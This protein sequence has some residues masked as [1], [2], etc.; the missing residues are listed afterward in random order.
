MRYCGEGRWAASILLL[1]LFVVVSAC[2][3]AA[4]PPAAQQPAAA[5]PPETKAAA[6]AKGKID[7]ITISAFN[8]IA[9][10]LPAFAAEKAG[11]FEKENIKVDWVYSNASAQVWQV[12]MSKDAQMVYGGWDPAL[13]SNSKGSDFVIIMGSVKYLLYSFITRPEIKTFQDLKGKAIGVSSLGVSRDPLLVK[14]PMRAEGI[15]DSEYDLVAV[16]GTASRYAALQSGAIVAGYL[17]PPEDFT[18]MDQGFPKMFDIWKYIPKY[19][20]IASVVSKAWAKNNPD[21]VVRY[22]KA[23]RAATTW[24]Y[25]PKNKEQVVQILVTTGPKLKEKAAQQFW[26]Y[27]IQNKVFSMGELDPEGVKVVVDGTVE[28]GQIPKAP[29]TESFIDMSYFEQAKKAQ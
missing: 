17:S 14:V 1:A 15:K 25:D 27:Y 12:L 10:L 11:F 19:E 8:P 22:I 26:D 21:L 4:P 28:I 24:I 9:G 5:K 2:A 7:V 18:A 29:P 6:P 16:G 20:W 13:V 3:S 23:M